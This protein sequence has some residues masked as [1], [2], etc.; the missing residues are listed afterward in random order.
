MEQNLRDKWNDFQKEALAAEK[1]GY[2]VSLPV[3]I[4]GGLGISETKF[5]VTEKPKAPSVFEKAAKSNPFKKADVN[6]G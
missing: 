6:D 4:S 3:N 5:F 1:S 2:N